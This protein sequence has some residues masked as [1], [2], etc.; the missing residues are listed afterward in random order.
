MRFLILAICIF[1]FTDMHPLI[2]QYE[3]KENEQEEAVVAL[4]DYDIQKKDSKE[5]PVEVKNK[6]CPVSLTRITTGD[7]FTYIYKGKIYR[8]S[9]AQ[10]IE[11]FK[12]DPEKYLKKWEKKER[13]YKIN[14]IYD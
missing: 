13:F 9:S 14:I 11:E 2:A 7:K 6:L 10:S 1:V 5:K 4:E 12:K 3:T 8:F